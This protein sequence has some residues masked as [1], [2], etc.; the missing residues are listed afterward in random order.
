D[1]LFVETSQDT[2]NIKAALL[3]IKKLSRELGVEVAVIVSVTIEPMRS[4]L[5]G[6]NIEAAWASLRHAKPLAF[7]M[8]CATGPEF[9]AD[10][11]R[12]L[13]A[14]TNEF[15]SCYPNAGVRDEEGKCLETPT[16]LAAQLEK[17]VDHAWL[18]LVGGCCGTTEQHIRAIAQMA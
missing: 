15:V 11:I 1:V 17:F 16:S 9:M 7:S 3:A 18:S 5:A 4:M 10:H 13:S 14:L 6:Q 12:T 2:R 8:N